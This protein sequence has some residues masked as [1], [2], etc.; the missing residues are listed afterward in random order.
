MSFRVLGKGP[1]AARIALR[2]GSVELRV[3]TA[4][5]TGNGDARRALAWVLANDP[6]PGGL[7]AELAAP[8][9]AVC[10]LLLGLARQGVPLA[11][12]GEPWVR[13]CAE[14]EGARHDG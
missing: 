5:I 3:A 2:E 14:A 4:V 1:G 6:P 7:I 10:R 11:S 12:W 13:R 9:E 8:T